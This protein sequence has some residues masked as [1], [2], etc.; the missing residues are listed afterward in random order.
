MQALRADAWVDRIGV[1][2]N[3]QVDAVTSRFFDIVIP[4]LQNLRIR[5]VRSGMASTGGEAQLSM[6]S[7]VAD[8]VGAR[9][10]LVSVKGVGSYSDMTGA[11][12][13]FGR[14]NAAIVRYWE[15]FNE[16]DNDWSDFGPTFGSTSGATTTNYGPQVLTFEAAKK[17]FRDTSSNPNVR[18]IK[19]VS[20][21]VVSNFGATHL[22]N[23]SQ[24]NDFIG[25]HPYL[26]PESPGPGLAAVLT[27]MA[28]MNPLGKPFVASEAGYETGVGVTSPSYLVGGEV[29]ELAQAKYTLRMFAEDEL[30]GLE[31]LTYY[32]FINDGSDPTNGEGNWGWIKGDGTPKI[33]YGTIQNTI[34]LLAETIYNVPSV[35]VGN[36]D[37][38][39][40]GFNRLDKN[41]FG[42]ADSGI[43]TNLAYRD[44]DG[45]ESGQWRVLTN[46]GLASVT[47]QVRQA[48]GDSHS[49]GHEVEIPFANIRAGASQEMRAGV[50]HT[51]YQNTYWAT[52]NPGVSNNIALVKIVGGAETT[53]LYANKTS[54][55]TAPAT[56]IKIRVLKVGND[57]WVSMKAYAPGSEPATWDLEF[58]D[59]GAASGVLGSGFAAFWLDNGGS[60]SISV[61]NIKSSSVSPTAGYWPTRAAFTLGKLDY[62]LSGS[63]P[64]VKQRLLQKSDGSFWL[65]LWN[66]VSVWNSTT[67]TDITNIAVPASLTFNDGVS[68]TVTVYNPRLGLTGI[69]QAAQALFTLDFSAD[70]RHVTSVN[71]FSVDFSS[72]F[73]HASGGSAVSNTFSAAFSSAFYKTA[74]SGGSSFTIPDE[75]IIVQIV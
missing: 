50:R 14:I 45:N 37:F 65:L 2:V 12:F 36:G 30:Q 43:D 9:F 62:T 11:T 47:Y 68:R 53:L 71:S 55:T 67:K 10:M 38:V 63:L 44:G 41:G 29:S 61:D 72:A 66:D 3:M 27:A 40:D 64:N 74:V 39:T 52:A 75:M 70:F 18:A 19:L 35:V 57:N 8:R 21:T 24:Y 73:T 31:A 28:P 6:I 4:A 26:Q 1:N 34:S 23:V 33:V 20:A 22:G 56:T 32:D 54:I 15:G 48:F 16:V 5:L 49:A 60:G 46:R 42:S 58:V 51:D 25:V 17:N 59:A 69:S 13:T 7:L